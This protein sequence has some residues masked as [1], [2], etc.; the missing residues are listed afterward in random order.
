MCKKIPKYKHLKFD[1]DI[2]FQS[3]LEKTASKSIILMDNGQGVSTI[4]I[5]EHGEIL[6]TDEDNDTFKGKFINTEKLAIDMP[7]L[8]WANEIPDWHIMHRLIPDQIINLKK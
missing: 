4:W 3:F 7:V 8:I 6:L 2:E 1:S 5:D